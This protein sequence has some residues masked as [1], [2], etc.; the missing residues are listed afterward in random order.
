MM[1]LF[2][3]TVICMSSFSLA[4]TCLEQFPKALEYKLPG[5]G[6][7]YFN[8]ADIKDGQTGGM[9]SGGVCLEGLDGWQLVTEAI[10]ISGVPEATAETVT[11]SF[12]GWQLQANFLQA[13]PAGLNMQ[14]IT[15]FGEGLQGLAQE[16]S[17]DFNTQE[18]TLLNATTQGQNLLI[19]G[20]QATLVDGQVFF[21]D[22]L[23]TT[24]NC[25]G[26]ALYKLLAQSA[27]FE[28]AT[29]KLFIK[30]GVLSV[31][32]LQVSLNDLELSPQ[33]LE[34]FSFPITIE[35]RADDGDT[36]G[37]G[38]GIR[39]PSLRADENLNLELGLVGLDNTYPL[40]GILLAHYKDSTR[41]FDVGY[42]AEGP[43]AD[44]T[45][46]QP[47]GPSTKAIFA[48]RNRHWDA[49]DFLHEGY[50]GLETSTLLPL[51]T[52]GNL[53][54]GVTAF[55][56]ISSQTLSHDPF[57]D[58][59][60]GIESTLAYKLVPQSLGQFDIGLKT[61]LTYYPMHERLQWG[62]RFSPSWQSQLGPLGIR[63]GFTQQWTNSASPFSKTLDKLEPSSQISLS[64]VLSGPL[65]SDV[66]GELNFRARYDL[67][68]ID[69]YF[70][71]GF[72]ELGFNAKL[73]WNYQ[74]LTLS[75]YL[76]GEFATLV[77]PALAK[78]VFLEGGFD[79]TAPRWEA[80]VSTR[81]DPSRG[82]LDKIE[83]RASFPI[84]FDA[85]TLKPYMALDILPTLVN[86]EFPRISGHGLEVILR[87]CCGTFS[88]GYRQ[89]ENNFKT[90]IGF[91]FE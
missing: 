48:V 4:E 40:S 16:A 70:G 45:L 57:H 13:S 6:L 26:D 69:R 9:F 84:D 32:G 82:A 36:K 7:L 76:T 89:Q 65:G 71:E 44:F 46:Q 49:Q 50:L 3:F 79:V 1:R 29:Q 2:I 38:L 63:L 12:Q 41:T 53:T 30:Q 78:D 67:F 54:F 43:Q 64:T 91:S 47:L 68:L 72:S 56:A 15:F 31:L 83:G 52:A 5:V 74:D 28:L 22:I 39:I 8:K 20:T 17:Y 87:T 73:S 37:T 33:S 19:E 59:R 61:N 24:C 51:Q 66:T 21:D 77:N 35:Y 75:P 42:A 88:V 62:I 10:E 81:F 14:G 80:G 27:T 86:S 23:A 18:L 55:S 60:L 90:L 11:V 58:G 34:D 85:V 25:E